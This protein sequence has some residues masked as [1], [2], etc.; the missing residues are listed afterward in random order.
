MLVS[1]ANEIKKDC[2]KPP[3]APEPQAWFGPSLVE[4]SGRVTHDY[5]CAGPSLAKGMSVHSFKNK[6]FPKPSQDMSYGDAR[7]SVSSR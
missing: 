6:T 4:F 7:Q 2:E 3:A 5:Y 1:Q